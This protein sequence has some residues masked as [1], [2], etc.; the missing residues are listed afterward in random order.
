MKKQAVKLTTKQEN[1][2]NEY[3]VDF[4]GT[5]AAL[6]A[7]YSK[8]NAR[9]QATENIAKPAIKAII[10]AKRAV[11]AEKTN[12]NAEWVRKRAIEIVE[13]CMQA[14][15][16]LDRDGNETGEY[17]FDANGAKAALD[18][19]NRMQG[20]YEIDNSQTKPDAVTTIVRVYE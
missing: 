8:K 19:L 7:G 13:R 3:M 11:L 17:K 5:Q 2:I 18:M 20:H 12:V 16:V 15:P 1:F 6:R 4:N 10:A 14:E 9:Q